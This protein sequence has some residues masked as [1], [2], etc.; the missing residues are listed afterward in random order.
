MGEDEK[1]I[2]MIE[3][4]SSGGYFFWY[5]GRLSPY[6]ITSEEARD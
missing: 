3:R 5:F 4:D 6:R 2:D 1:I